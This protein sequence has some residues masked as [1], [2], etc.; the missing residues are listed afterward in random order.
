[1]ST[2]YCSEE[3]NFLKKEIRS[4]HAEAN[5]LYFEYFE[6]EIFEKSVLHILPKIRIL[7]S[8]LVILAV[9]NK[10]DLTTL[11]YENKN[12]LGYCLLDDNFIYSF[13]NK[14]KIKNLTELINDI[15]DTLSDYHSDELDYKYKRLISLLEQSVDIPLKEKHFNLIKSIPFLE[16]TEFSLLDVYCN[17]QEEYFESKNVKE[18]KKA[19]IV[20]LPKKIEI[21][22]EVVEDISDATQ[23]SEITITPEQDSIKKADETNEKYSKLSN[24]ILTNIYQD[25]KLSEILCMIPGIE[26]PDYYKFKNYML[27]VL[28]LEIDF[29]TETIDD[30]NKKYILGDLKKIQEALEFLNIYFSDL[31]KEIKEEQNES[32]SKNI[33][34]YANKNNGDS[35]LESDLLDKENDSDDFNDKIQELIE[36]LE[37]GNIDSN[38]SKSRKFTNNKSLTGLFELKAN[39]VRLLYLHLLDNNYYVIMACTKKS[40]NDKGI[41]EKIKSRYDYCY[42]DYKIIKQKLINDKK[43]NSQVP[44]IK[45]EI[46]KN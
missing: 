20:D 13:L 42:H 38:L 14:H 19:P 4:I 32:L 9:Q 30:N 22:P 28:S 1:M 23:L 25:N 41:K 3:L 21:I 17:L 7:L 16:D 10:E 46:N 18:T 15:A 24:L 6:N 5:L 44:G 2:I 45:P 39:G 26:S 27:K 36:K 8:K 37:N 34:Y 33:I 43:E 31:E 40:Q 11:L 12:L 29:F 35:F